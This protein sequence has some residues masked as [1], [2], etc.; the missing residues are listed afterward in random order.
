MDFSTASKFESSK[1]C[2][3]SSLFFNSRSTNSFIFCS[4]NQITLAVITV[5]SRIPR[6][7]GGIILF[8]NL[9]WTESVSQTGVNK[10]VRPS[11]RTKK[12]LVQDKLP[13][14]QKDRS[15][16]TAPYNIIVS[17]KA[18]LF[19]FLVHQARTLKT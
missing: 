18:L 5:I 17:Q 13:A 6:K 11:I 1:S 19:L 3:Y 15:V 8:S 4:I 12:A 7:M 16:N 2:P 10:A 9:F 14:N